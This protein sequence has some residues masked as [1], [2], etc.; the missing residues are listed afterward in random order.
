MAD[1]GA[2][3]ANT[4]AGQPDLEE[5]ERLSKMRSAYLKRWREQA[6]KMDGKYIRPAGASAD[7]FKPPY[8]TSQLLEDLFCIPGSK[9]MAATLSNVEHNINLGLL[10]FN[11]LSW[12]PATLVCNVCL[13]FPQALDPCQF[14]NVAGDAFLEDYFLLWPRLI[15][16]SSVSKPNLIAFSIESPTSVDESGGYVFDDNQLVIGVMCQFRLDPEYNR[17]D[18]FEDLMQAL[19]AYAWLDSKTEWA[20]SESRPV[21]L[22]K[23]CDLFVEN[24]ELLEAKAI[25]DSRSHSLRETAGDEGKVKENNTWQSM[26]RKYEEELGVDVRVVPSALKAFFDH[27][28]SPGLRAIKSGGVIAINPDSVPLQRLTNDEREAVGLD[29]AKVS[30]PDSL[31]ALEKAFNTSVSEDIHPG[32]TKP[33]YKRGG[34]IQIENNFTYQSLSWDEYRSFVRSETSNA[35]MALNRASGR[36]DICGYVKG[37]GAWLNNKKLLGVGYAPS[38]RNPKGQLAS[39]S[40]VRVDLPT[41]MALGGKLACQIL[42]FLLDRASLVSHGDMSSESDAMAEKNLQSRLVDYFFQDESR[43]LDT[44]WLQ[45]NQSKLTE[46]SVIE[47]I[48]QVDLVVLVR[49]QQASLLEALIGYCVH[50]GQVPDAWLLECAVFDRHGEAGLS[51]VR[52]NRLLCQ[53]CFQEIFVIKRNFMV[54]LALTST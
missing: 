51:L 37:L 42:A 17:D 54:V 4:L 9:I 47:L 2:L 53:V 20:D 25:A 1:Q 18:D 22:I 40:P 46:A 10:T 21:G 31:V 29:V 5:D 14:M 16:G 39:V 27:Y 23:A 41:V 12:D 26:V 33:S 24:F 30:Y 19:V 38:L 43:C 45:D 35:F 13:A 34:Q 8:D 11:R 7:A 3:P 48:S 28:S 49:Q 44:A 32:M 6:K 52:E 15:K 36:G 50:L